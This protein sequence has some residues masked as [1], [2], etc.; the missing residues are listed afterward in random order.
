MIGWAIF[1]ALCGL[2]MMLVAVW[3]RP[4]KNCPDCKRELEEQNHRGFFAGERRFCP[5]CK[6]EEDPRG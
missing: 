1:W 4:L 2:A 6:W 3:P 5:Y